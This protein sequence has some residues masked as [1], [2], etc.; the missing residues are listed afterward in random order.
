MLD[1]GRPMA[2]FREVDRYGS[3]QLRGSGRPEL[4]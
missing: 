4:D 3:E 1:I 2:H